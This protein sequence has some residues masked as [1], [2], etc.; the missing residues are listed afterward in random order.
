MLRKAKSILPLVA[1]AVLSCIFGCTRSQPQASDEQVRAMLQVLEGRS[2]TSQ[3]SRPAVDFSQAPQIAVS[4]INGDEFGLAEALCRC[5]TDIGI[6][7]VDNPS[8]AGVVLSGTV[9]YFGD[10]DD[11]PSQLNDIRKQAQTA[12]VAHAATSIGMGIANKFSLIKSGAN[13]LA[14]A[15]SDAM[16]PHKVQGVVILHVRQGSEIWDVVLDQTIE[17]PKETANQKLAQ[18][19]A[20]N[21]LSQLGR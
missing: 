13:L 2:Q 5:I 18:M 6:E 14:S 10:P 9:K 19:L 8:G 20:H 16:E 17:E 21:A 7:L 11:V 12:E 3:P 4:Q 1:F 15:V